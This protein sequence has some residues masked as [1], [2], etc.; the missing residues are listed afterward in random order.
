VDEENMKRAGV[1]FILRK[2]FRLEQ[3]SEMITKI[4]FSRIN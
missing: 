1:D 4:R 3:L 2:P